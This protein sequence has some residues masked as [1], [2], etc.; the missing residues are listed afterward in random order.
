MY[1]LTICGLLLAYWDL[2]E[3]HLSEK[4]TNLLEYHEQFTINNAT[5][6]IATII[7]HCMFI[8]MNLE[9]LWCHLWIYKNHTHR[10]RYTQSKF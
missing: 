2:W 4:T 6:Y 3:V 10:Y 9:F 5:Y 1:L 7:K 8:S